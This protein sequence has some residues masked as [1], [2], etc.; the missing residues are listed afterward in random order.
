MVTIACLCGV[1]HF[2]VRVLSLCILLFIYTPEGYYNCLVRLYNNTYM[3]GGLGS[4]CFKSIVT[5]FCSW[6]NVSFFN[7]YIMNLFFGLIA[8]I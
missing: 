5:L 8:I 4:D 1:T 7:I 6:K 2:E 3:N